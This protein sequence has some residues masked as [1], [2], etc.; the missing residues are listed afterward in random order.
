MVKPSQAACCDNLF[1]MFTFQNLRI[2]APPYGRGVYAIRIRKRSKSG[3]EISSQIKRLI[4]E[5]GWPVVG[6]SI[7]GRITRLER[8]AQCPII[9]IGSAGTRTDSSNT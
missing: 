4:D 3:P 8:I 5:L 2:A 9:Y 6:G 7:L 1:S